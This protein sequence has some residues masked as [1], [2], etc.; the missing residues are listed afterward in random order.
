MTFI[1]TN[2]FLRVYQNDHK[3]HSK[4]AQDFFIQ[5]A[6]TNKKCCSSIIVFFETYWL[7]SKHFNKTK[8]V[9]QDTLVNILDL[10]FITW[11]NQ[12]IIT[13]AVTSMHKFNFDLEDSY[14]F[15][16]AKSKKTT[17]FVTFDNNLQ[18]KWKKSSIALQ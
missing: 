5:A 18:S 11:E 17:H 14:N 15:Y 12:E 16:Y 10:K 2:Y 9:L 8:S 13:Q 1:D 6:E 4:T 3:E 7:L